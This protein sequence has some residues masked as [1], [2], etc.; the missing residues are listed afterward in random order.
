MKGRPEVAE[1][2]RLLRQG[3]NNSEVARR[4]GSDRRTVARARE[5][6]GIPNSAA[7]R[8]APRPVTPSRRLFAE[9]VPTGRV[10]E[11]RPRLMPLSPDHQRA[12]RERLLA[13]LRDEAA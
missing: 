12:N 6:L 4:T 8:P 7:R 5:R 13:A 3:F 9:A 10:R 1:I 11:Y 2:V